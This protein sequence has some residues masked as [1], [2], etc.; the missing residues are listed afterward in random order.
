M[1]ANLLYSGLGLLL[2]SASSQA[3]LTTVTNWGN[4]P[5]GLTMAI[6][7][8]A[9]VAQKPAIVLA[10]H[11]CGGSGSQYYNMANY[12]SYAARRGFITIYPSSTRDFNCWDV[13]TQAT[14][15]HGGGGDS[16]GLVNMV[17]YVIERYGADPTKV[18]ATGSSSGCM[19]TNVLL[20]AYPDV[21]AAGSCYSG[22]AANCLAGS[23]G[24]SPI[25]ADPKC[26]NGQ[27]IKTGDQWAQLVK[28]MYP[29]YTGAYP[30]MQTLHGTADTL[31]T[32]P[33]LGEQLK[34]WST[35]LG[36]QF[37]SNVTNTPQSGYT[38]MVYGDGTKLVGYSAAGVGHTVPVNRD[39]DMAW[40][41]LT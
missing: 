11:P 7:V 20:A 35:L 37:S 12:D 25:S 28:A 21:F 39:L 6:S 27:N 36:V 40:F 22:V 30:R 14:L 26:A 5:T 18:Y 1:V 29:G 2:L 10:L 9:T 17:N 13:A 19:M 32:Y 4:N 3:A 33:N 15:T 24:S 23:P 16:N 41:G 8:P 34:E 31:V 38:K